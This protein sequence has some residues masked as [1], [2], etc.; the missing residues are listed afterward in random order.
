MVQG[1]IFGA[2]LFVTDGFYFIGEESLRNDIEAGLVEF[3]R[4]TMSAD[5]VVYRPVVGQRTDELH[6]EPFRIIEQ[7]FAYRESLP[8]SP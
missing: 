1:Q 2:V 8:D 3:E 7:D 4:G 6:S 5:Q